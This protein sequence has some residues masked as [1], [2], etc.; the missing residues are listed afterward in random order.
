M[1]IKNPSMNLS[2]A[3]ET[4]KRSNNPLTPLF[5]AITN[6]LESIAQRK[7]L[8]GEIHEIDVILHFTGLINE[9]KQLIEIE[10]IDNGSGFTEENFSRFV[11]F[12]DK[13]KGYHNRGTGRLQYFHCFEKVKINSVFQSNGELFRRTFECNKNNFID[14]DVVIKAEINSGYKTSIKLLGHSTDN[15][16]IP[17]FDHLTIEDLVKEIKSHFLLRFYLDSKKDAYDVPI[18]NVTFFKDGEIIEK[19]SISRE[20][21]KEPASEGEISVCYMRVADPSADTISWSKVKDKEESIK[22][23]HFILPEAE[24]AKN[25]IYLCSKDV[26]VQKVKSSHIN[27]NESIQGKR[28]L[29]AF[30]GDILD[31]P[32]NVSDSVDQFIF[33]QKKDVEKRVEDL[34]FNPSEEFIFIETIEEEVDKAIPFIYNDIIEKKEQHIGSVQEI[35]KAHGIS[36]DTAGKAKIKIGDNEKTIT[37]KIYIAQSVELAD[38]GYKVKKIF[39]ELKNLDPTS[40]TYQHEIQ[41]RTK[42]LSKLVDEQN[43]EELSRYIIRREMVTNILKKIINNELNTQNKSTE[44]GERKDREGLIHDLIFKRKLKETKS[45]NDLWILNEEYV[46]FDGCSDSELNKITTL[47]GKNLLQN[48]PQDV[49]N[50]LGLRL[51]KRPDIFLYANEGKCLII[52]IKEPNVDMSKH[53]NQMQSYCSIIANFGVH[54]INSFFCY[55]IGE[56]INP[57][58]DLDGEYKNTPSGDWLRPNIPIVTL[59]QNRNT[60]AT[61]QIEI[62]KLSNIHARAH[63]RNQSFAEKLGLPDLL[64]IN[65]DQ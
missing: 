5:E 8:E 19:K 7:F 13:S 61:A 46:H 41:E 65:N 32:E 12:F 55:L 39:D 22:W 43:K 27:T 58:T 16:D 29:T 25:G 42:E 54:K 44:P 53:L 57:L 59:D 52:E 2:G 47:D 24:L 56:Q 20:S 6:S 38:K 17:Y 31:K 63:R 9:V 48:I 28:Y 26:P 4:I 35:A 3:M 45:L 33:P 23:A 14:N 1:S 51:T 30:Y 40:E 10:I 21:I 18:I 49:I 50:D 11:E 34:F 36:M 64:R 15:S 62:I 60:I 37:Q